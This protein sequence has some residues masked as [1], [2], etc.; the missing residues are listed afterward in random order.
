LIIV[1][2]AVLFHVT[3]G[4]NVLK[5]SLSVPI[6]V[7]HLVVTSDIR[8]YFRNKPEI[9][10]C[11]YPRYVEILVLPIQN[12]NPYESSPGIDCL[13]KSEIKAPYH[14]NT[15]NNAE[16]NHDYPVLDVIQIEIFYLG[17]PLI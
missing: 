11:H 3:N 12:F 8:R 7:K 15:K 14:N 6:L 5:F 9:L 17:S 10:L 13:H 2:E 4:V 1:C 16:W